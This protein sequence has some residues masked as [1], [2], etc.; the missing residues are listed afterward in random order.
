MSSG[1]RLLRAVSKGDL[2]WR[3]VP[4]ASMSKGGLSAVSK[5]HTL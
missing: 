4:Q 2:W 5:V 1:E 3:L